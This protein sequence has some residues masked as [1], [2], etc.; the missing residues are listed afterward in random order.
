LATEIGK[1]NP[2]GLQLFDGALRY[3]DAMQKRLTALFASVWLAG[4]AAHPSA[5]AT[6]RSK[7]DTDV[8][9]ACEERDRETASGPASTPALTE[10]GRAPTRVFL[11]GPPAASAAQ[12]IAPPA[13]RWAVRQI[14]SRADERP[15]AA[16]PKRTKRVDIDLVRAPFDETARLLSDAGRFNVVVEAPS[17][18]A[19]TVHLKSIEPYDALVV[20]AEARGLSIRF[21]HGV[22]VVGGA[23]GASQAN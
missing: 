15:S 8:C 9:A 14:G 7:P 10:N 18:S 3:A 21:E 17:A 11:E 23:K 6:A 19:V 20:L 13:D 2:V 12:G 1:N 22:V 4:C 5:V 16:R